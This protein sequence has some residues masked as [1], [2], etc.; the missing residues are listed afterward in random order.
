MWSLDSNSSKPT[1][2]SQPQL[3]H[4]TS[5]QSVAASLAASEGYYSAS[6]Q[7]SSSSEERQPAYRTPPSAHRTPA[8]S[9]EQLVPHTDVPITSL[10]GIGIPRQQPQRPQSPAVSTIAEESRPDTRDAR[11]SQLLSNMDAESQVTTPGQDTTPY[12]RFAIDQLTR[13]EEVRGSRIYPEVRP[14]DDEDDYPVDRIVHDNGLGYMAQE[15]RT[16]QRMSQ[17][18]PRKPLRIRQHRLRKPQHLWLPR[19]LTTRT[20]NPSSTGNSS[21]PRLLGHKMTFS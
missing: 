13:D 5:Q 1:V 11:R 17:K 8:Q 3:S 21:R 9:H 20:T 7:A 16:Q 14:E 12:I 18:I 15:Q 6:E 10:R 4:Q 19:N 2:V